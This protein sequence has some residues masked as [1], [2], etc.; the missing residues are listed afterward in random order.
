M[1]LILWAS[2]DIGR[3]CKTGPPSDPPRQA[4]GRGSA[5]EAAGFISAVLDYETTMDQNLRPEQFTIQKEERNKLMGAQIIT[6]DQSYNP[7]VVSG[8]VQG[9]GIRV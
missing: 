4:P 2:C 7:G 9:L 5:T 6:V 1:R 8:E 3:T